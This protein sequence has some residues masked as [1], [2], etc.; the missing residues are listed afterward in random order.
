MPSMNR[1]LP[2]PCLKVV[3]LCLKHR[4]TDGPASA[5]TIATQ[6]LPRPTRLR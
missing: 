3:L 2:T 6:Q 4:R 5:A 1:A